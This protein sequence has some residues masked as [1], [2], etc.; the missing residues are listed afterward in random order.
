MNDP[1]KWWFYLTLPAQKPDTDPITREQTRYARLTSTFL[2]IIL[3]VIILVTP[4]SLINASNADSPY[5]A[6]LALLSILFAWPASRLGY[7]VVAASLIVMSIIIYVVGTMLTNPL[8]PTIIPVFGAFVLPIILAGSLM[9]PIAALFTGFLT[10]A[11]IILISILQ[12]HT[13]LYDQMLAKGFYS[14]F[15]IVPIAIQ[16]VVGLVIFVIMRNYSAT[17]RRADRAEEIIL[18][19]KELH[20]HEQQRLVDQLQ[21]EEGIAL[22]AQVHTS[23]ANGDL[24]ARVTLP[25]EHPLWP[26]TGPLNN[27]LNRIQRWKRNS[28]QFERTQYVTNKI[29]GDLQRARIQN[30]IVLYPHPTGTPLDPLLPEISYLSERSSRLNSSR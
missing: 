28:D 1:L 2:L 16:L 21:L 18:L 24:E 19:Q 15:I 17:V 23:I 29:M 11:I 20:G 7:N 22:V 12:P 13:V 14:V 9:P 25:M 8:D 26:I 4:L 3:V 5:I 10:S 30:S 6:I 27:L